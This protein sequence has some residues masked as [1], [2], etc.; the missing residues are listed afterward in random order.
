MQNN[1]VDEIINTDKENLLEDTTFIV[2]IDDKNTRIDKYLSDELADVSRSRI[3]KLLDEGMIT[4]NNN[5][6][7]SNYK[8]AADDIINVHIPELV[9]PE[10]V[11]EDISLDIVYE[12]DDI[13]VINKPKGMVVHPAAGHYSGTLVN[14][15]MYHCRDNLSGINGVLRPGIVHRIDMNTTGVIVACKNDYAHNFIAQQLSVHSITRKYYAIVHN[16][17]NN[18]EGV[19]DAPIGRNPSDRKKMAVDKKNGKRAV[20]HYRV[21]EQFGKFS[22]I[23][24]QLETGRT[25]QIRVH[26]ASIHHPLLGD[27]VYNH[28]KCPFKLEGQCLHAKTI[29][30]IHPTTKKYVEFEAPI[31]EYM[32][33]LLKIL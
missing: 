31:P 20:T 27:T 21:L 29:G 5:K 24:C 28:N 33:H 2:D 23:E 10:I 3:Q 1:M 30:F 15:L 13:I 8:V 19:V 12:D 9:V 16:Q 22:Y 17:F 7:K 25:H 32:E 26:M 18:T 11:P 14:A 6:V 4:V